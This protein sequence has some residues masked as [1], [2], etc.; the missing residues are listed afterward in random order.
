MLSCLHACCKH[1]LRMDVSHSLCFRTIGNCSDQLSW[2]GMGCTSSQPHGVLD[3]ERNDNTAVL[4]A[5][6]AL[7]STAIHWSLV[8]NCLSRSICCCCCCLLNTNRLPC[9]AA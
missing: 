3:T 6:R 4:W 2:T 8:P 7:Q 5:C 9:K 1:L